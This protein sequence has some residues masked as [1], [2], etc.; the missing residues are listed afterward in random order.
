MGTAVF[1]SSDLPAE[2]QTDQK[3]ESEGNLQNNAN[4]DVEGKDSVGDILALA[5][6]EENEKSEERQ[7]SANSITGLDFSENNASVEY[8]TVFLLADP[9]M[10]IQQFPSKYWQLIS[11][12]KVP[13]VFSSFS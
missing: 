7:K 13:E 1:A 8:P 11:R 3:K 9:M 2:T 6:S 10:Q 4:I 12:S 5:I